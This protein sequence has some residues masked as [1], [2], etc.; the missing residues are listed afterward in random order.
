[1]ATQTMSKDDILEAIGNMS[2]FELAE[3]IEAFKSKFGVTI[4]APAAAPAGGAAP[5]GAAAA[6][7]VEEKTEFTVVL[8]AGGEK[9][10]QVIKEIRAITSLGLK[11]AK[12][13]V[14]GAPG[15]VKEGVSKQEAEEI[16][17]KLEAQGAVVELK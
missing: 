8:K 12:D 2:V 5:G 10:I 4:A 13:L 11:E 9:K 1:M 6:P 7:A 14:E 3:L 15:T 16:K 17:K